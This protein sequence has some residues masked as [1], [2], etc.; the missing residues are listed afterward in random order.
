MREFFKS[1]AIL[2]A[3][4][5]CTVAALSAAVYAS[6]KPDAP[7]DHSRFLVKREATKRDAREADSI[8]QA[9]GEL[10]H[11]I[12]TAR[13][14]GVP[15]SELFKASDTGSGLSNFDRALILAAFDMPRFSSEAYRRQAAEN[16]RNDVEARCYKSDRSRS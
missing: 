11:A 10:A 7:T 5:G 14:T 4:C 2:L 1:N 6:G 13:Q 8:C 9:L 3:V 15:I 16:F 12:M